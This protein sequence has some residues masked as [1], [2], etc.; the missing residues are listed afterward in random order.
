MKRLMVLLFFLPA[1]ALI[2]AQNSEAVIQEING[3]VELKTGVSA[4]WIQANAGDRIEKSTI[5][6]TGIK[7]TALL[8]LGN[9]TVLVRPLTCLS[10]EEILLLNDPETVSLH[11]QSGRIKVDVH[12]PAG[13]KADFSVQAPMSLASVRGTSFEQDTL[14]IFVIEGTVRYE[15]RAKRGQVV[16][17]SGGQSSQVDTVTGSLMNPL[18]YSAIDRRLPDLPGQHAMAEASNALRS[19]MGTLGLNLDLIPIE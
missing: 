4:D 5:I 6:N 3:M 14:K 12:P 19:P 15:S 10:L 8:E 11:L 13:G 17:V 18:A 9:A 7:S 1:A 2:F 16:L